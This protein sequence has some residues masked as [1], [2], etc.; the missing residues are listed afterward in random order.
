MDMLGG[1]PLPWFIISD[2]ETR[3]N[4]NTPE[5]VFYDDLS[6]DEAKKT[7]DILL[8]HSYKCFATKLTY[9]AYKDIPT[10]YQYCKKDS[11]L[12]IF[13]QEKMVE[14]ARALGVQIDTDTFDASHS[15]FLSMPDAVIA[16]CKR[17][18]GGSS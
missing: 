9:P 3:V 2:N 11:A 4:A 5:E 8:H 17:A 1:K 14:D 18:A 10:T 13:A 15:P 16:A 6:A 7:A 12:P